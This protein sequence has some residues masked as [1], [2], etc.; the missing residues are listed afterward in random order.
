VSDVTAF[1][2]RPASGFS[3]ARP[4]PHAV[5]YD[6]LTVPADSLLAHFP[7]PDWPGWHRYNDEYQRNK[8][9]CSD[10]SRIPT[11]LAV[12]IRELHSPDFLRFLETLTGISG[13]IP[14]PYLEGAGLHLSGPGGVLLP[15]TD[16][17]I[18]ARLG[19]FR[20]IN[21]I[22]YLNPGWSAEQGG[23][24]CLYSDAKGQ[25]VAKR[26]VPTWGTS[27]VFRTDHRSVH[28]FPEPI[29]GPAWRRSIALYYY[30]SKENEAF[31]GDRVSYWRSGAEQHGSNRVRLAGFR[32]LR[33]IA[34]VLSAAAH[35][36][37]PN[38]VAR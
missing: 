19:L 20:Q 5:F 28:G 1:R 6:F 36:L 32:T 4:F 23:N 11:P 15:H 21:L 33:G 38:R 8:R 35:R 27:V 13:L 29:T 3:E 12:V 7:H 18:Y 30:T 25:H 34:R 9:A 24:L 14:D 2:L 26:I 10:M 37:D 16:F 17:H 31:S 22:L